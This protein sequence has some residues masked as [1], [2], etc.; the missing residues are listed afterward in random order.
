MYAAS[1]VFLFLMAAPPQQTPQIAWI[2][3]VTSVEGETIYA[4]S[5][6][7]YPALC[8]ALRADAIATGLSASAPWD[9]G[10]VMKALALETIVGFALGGPRTTI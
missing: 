3:R 4:S 7:S 2:R 10:Q 1:V 5:G 9:A 6:K 8:K